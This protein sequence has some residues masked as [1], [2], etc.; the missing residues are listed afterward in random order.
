MSSVTADH[1][2]QIYLWSDRRRGHW[3]AQV[4]LRGSRP[5][6]LSG[7]TS[8]SASAHSLLSIALTS[9]LSSITKR[10]LDRFAN[11]RVRLRIVTADQ[12]FPTALTALK[13]GDRQTRVPFRAAK[14]FLKTLGRSM[15]RFETVIEMAGDQDH[16]ALAALAQ[17][18]QI[19][20]RAL[21]A[22]FIA[23]VFCPDVVRV[24]G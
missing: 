10:K 19:H 21:Q 14:T 2:G 5:T 18:A 6:T 7:K 24:V 15:A 3:A 4:Q 12:T 1:D 23:P 11:P 13:T 16:G 8:A 9:G 20:L 17:F 22:Q